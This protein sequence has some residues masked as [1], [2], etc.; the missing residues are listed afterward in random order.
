MQD[1][2]EI[3][4][5]DSD[6]IDD[7]L[8]D[9]IV[10]VESDGNEDGYSVETLKDIWMESKNDNFVCIIHGN[11]I[12]HIS[13]NPFSLRRN[14]SVY[15]INLV[16]SPNY[17]RKG[18]ALKLIKAGCEYYLNRKCTLPISLSV[19]KDNFPAIMLY[20][21]IGFE[22]KEPMNDIEID[23]TQYIMESSFN[24][25]YQI[26]CQSEKKRIKDNL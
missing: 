13:F 22:I 17:R 11:V 12:G 26:I 3:Y 15:C 1:E 25:V 6:H 5:V 14:G 8:F 7:G 16:V 2:F 18:V 23:D 21:K 10:K 9:Q 4:K 24:C 20:Q 19:D